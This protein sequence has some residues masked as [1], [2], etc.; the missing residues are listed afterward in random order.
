M[1]MHR[2]TTKLFHSLR[3]RH[4]QMQGRPYVRNQLIPK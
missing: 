2:P 1:Q 3:A 4:M